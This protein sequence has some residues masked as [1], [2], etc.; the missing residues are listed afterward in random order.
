MP[1]TFGHHAN[2]QI[3][4]Q[5]VVDQCN[6]DD[7]QRSLQLPTFQRPFV[8]K[9]KKIKRLVESVYLGYPL[10]FVTLFLPTGDAAAVSAWLE[11][12]DD[13]VP[14]AA[15]IIDGQQRS[16]ALCVIHDKRPRWFGEGDWQAV[17]RRVVFNPSTEEVRVL[18]LEG[19][20]PQEGEVLIDQLLRWGED[21]VRDTVPDKLHQQRLLRLRKQLQNSTVGE[22]AFSGTTKQAVESFKRLNQEGE[23][24]NT[25]DLTLTS[26]AL[27]RPEWVRDVVRAEH[28]TLRGSIPKLK[29]ADVMRPFA[30]RWLGT[31]RADR[32]IEADWS[33]SEVDRHWEST[34]MGWTLAVAYLRA[35]GIL[36]RGSV[37]VPM[38][39]L[40]PLVI[41]FSL[42]G[43]PAEPG[44][45]PLWWMIGA[46]TQGRYKS[47]TVNNI[48]S[49]ANDLEA[50]LDQ[51]DFTDGLLYLWEVEAGGRF[52]PDDFL[53]KQ[54]SST[55]QA[56]GLVV[57]TLTS[58]EKDWSA[59]C[60]P[61]RPNQQVQELHH[62][63]PKEW[64]RQNLPTR[65][66]EALA[67]ANTTVIS[68][69]A[70]NSIGARS[71]RLYLADAAGWDRTALASHF[72][73]ADM[74]ELVTTRAESEAT[75]DAFLSSRAEL[76]AAEASRQYR[77]ALPSSSS[78]P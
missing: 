41:L 50:L 1:A 68:D 29:M 56:Q 11:D 53:Q 17:R 15:W 63:F 77:H 34:S 18:K 21:T 40:L 44:D 35:R 57:A 10:G 58:R 2:G 32:L 48:D 19:T 3:T 72:V 4:L 27:W 69:S 55:V 42:K 54:P 66:D 71:P 16:T 61:M 38:S 47:G 65:R 12:D 74:V 14:N 78:A 62:I 8:W 46:M 43:V 59:S 5:E 73:T 25:W 70:N 22:I 30:A 9:D 67:Y 45:G 52:A 28:N 36:V 24:V 37:Q 60:E 31:T 76:I 7:V 75:M 23:K 13:E 33:V 6:S 49:V 20:A 51:P 26:A 64:V 39:Y